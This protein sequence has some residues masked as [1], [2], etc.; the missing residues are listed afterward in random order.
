LDVAVM[1]GLER[2]HDP[3]VVSVV[4]TADSLLIGGYS[5]MFKQ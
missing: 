2:A 4:E 1:I 3:F 5:I